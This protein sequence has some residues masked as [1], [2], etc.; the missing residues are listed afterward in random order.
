MQFGGYPAPLGPNRE[1]DL[2]EGPNQGKGLVEER[3]RRRARKLQLEPAE[4]GAVLE[5]LS[6]LNLHFPVMLSSARLDSKDSNITPLLSLH[7]ILT[8]SGK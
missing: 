5:L 7:E 4:S 2:R 3:A 6:V 8:V 1:G